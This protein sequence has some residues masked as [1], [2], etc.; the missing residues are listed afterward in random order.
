ML[1]FLFFGF[2]ALSEPTNFPNWSPLFLILAVILAYILGV[3][4]KK[5]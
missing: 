1:T 4:D 2:A 5:D 3:Y